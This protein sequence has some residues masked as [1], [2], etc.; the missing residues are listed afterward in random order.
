MK[1]ASPFLVHFSVSSSVVFRVPVSD[2][3]WRSLRNETTRRT[4][5][6]ASVLALGP[7]NFEELSPRELCP[8]LRHRN[9]VLA[10]PT[11]RTRALN[12]K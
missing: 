6:F 8:E 10:A 5:P 4:G 9:D 12:K 2:K 3:R 11:Q 1:R 7:Q